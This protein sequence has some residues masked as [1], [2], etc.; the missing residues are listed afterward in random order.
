MSRITQFAAAFALAF[1]MAQPVLASLPCEANHASPCASGCPMA[2]SEMG[3][4]CPMASQ[5]MMDA[6]CLQTCCARA[7][8]QTFAPA[9]GAGKL[10]AGVAA[11]PLAQL[12]T[13]L[14][15]NRIT[16]F[17][18]ASEVRGESP[19]RYIVNQVFRI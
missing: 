9:V 5:H 3:A 1:L 7:G 17:G 13:V 11:V 10:R 4:D 15:A 2:M 6:G 18:R 14:P 12:V 16:G 19:P 8:L